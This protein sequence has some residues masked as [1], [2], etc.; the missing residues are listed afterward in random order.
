MTPN[1]PLLTEDDLSRYEWQMSVHGVGKEG[2][3]RLK[4]ASVLISRVGGVGSLVAYELAAAGVGRLILAHAG[5]VKPSDLNRQILMTHDWIGKPRVE[6][7]A[8]RLTELNPNIEI[9]PICENISEKNAMDI[10]AQADLVVDCAPRFQERFALNRAAVIQKKA[11]IEC[12][13]YEFEGHLTTIIPGETGCL[14]CL[15]PEF[16]DYWKRQFPVFGAVA[17]SMGSMG[18]V[19]AIKYICGLQSDLRGKLLVADLKRMTF[20]RMDSRRL[21][22]CPVCSHLQ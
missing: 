8:R 13:M 4:G 18:A 7:A 20:R 10:L 11:L 2:Q 15:Y 14:N 12:A 5:N 6:S 1:L 17:G 16:P 3:R 19:E 22:S 9:V 21:P